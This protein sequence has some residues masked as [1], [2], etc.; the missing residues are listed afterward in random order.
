M[1]AGP[2]GAVIWSAAT[3]RRLHTLPSPRGDRKA[4]FSPD[5]QP[6]RDGGRRLERRGCGSPAPAAS[7][8][9]MP[10]HTQA[11]TD[12]AFSNDGRRLATSS[13]DADGRICERRHRSR[14]RPRAKLRSARSRRSTS[15]P[16]GSGSPPR[17]RSASSSGPPA[18]GA[19]SST[20]GGTRRLLTGVSFAPRAP[21]VLSS[22]TDGTLRTYTCNVCIDLNWLVRLAELRLARTG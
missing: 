18:P 17:A 2:R 10:R 9:L 8:A 20:S 21:T 6:G 1:S 12:V 11:V 3:G 19:S 13:E 5:G 4:V 7:I 16:T 14:I 22:S 15:T